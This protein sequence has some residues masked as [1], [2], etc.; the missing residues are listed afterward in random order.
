MVSLRPPTPCS[1]RII[2]ERWGWKVR[3]PDYRETFKLGSA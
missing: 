2:Q 3:V 1:L